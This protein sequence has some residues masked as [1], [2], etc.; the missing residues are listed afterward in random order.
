MTERE[1]LGDPYLIKLVRDDV[2]ASM[3]NPQ[4][5]IIYQP[6]EDHD[7]R[8]EALRRKLGEEVVEYLLNPSIGELVDI[9]EA[10]L[11]LAQCDL[12]VSPTQI[13]TRRLAKR[14]ERGGFDKGIGMWAVPS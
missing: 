4:H 8:I 12:K 7:R 9:E 1:V 10:C 3:E 11:A 13:E 5:G 6:I 2:E 14:R